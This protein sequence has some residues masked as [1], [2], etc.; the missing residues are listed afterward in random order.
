[1]RLGDC[2]PRLGCSIEEILILIAHAGCHLNLVEGCLGC[3]WHIGFWRQIE[4]VCAY[5]GSV[6][7]WGRRVTEIYEQVGNVFFIV[8]RQ[9]RFSYSQVRFIPAYISPF[10]LSVML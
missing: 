10:Q 6:G 7:F 1:M 4:S 8:S 3:P 2:F 9:V 5:M